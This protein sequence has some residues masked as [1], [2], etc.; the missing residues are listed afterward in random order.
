VSKGEILHINFF[1]NRDHRTLFTEAEIELALSTFM[2][3]DEAKV[4]AR[5]M[6]EG[7]IVPGKPACFADHLLDLLSNISPDTAER[8]RI[9]RS[10]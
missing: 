9:A 8:V 2:L 4:M 3:P 7:P 6:M 5:E 10:S 1:S